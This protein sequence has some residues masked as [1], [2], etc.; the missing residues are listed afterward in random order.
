MNLGTTESASPRPV[1]AA[2]RRPTSICYCAH[3]A[4]L[5]TTTRVVILQ[6]P[7]ERDVAIGTARMA[8]LCLPNSELHVGVRWSDSPALARVLSDPARPAVLL[9]P[10]EG[11]IDVGCCPPSGP[12]TLVVVDGTWWQARKVIR[13]NPALA[14]LPRY[15]FVPPSPSEYR[16]RRE[17]ASA[18]VSTI[19]A[20]AHVLGVLEGDATRFSAL[21]A[22][23]RAMIDAQIAC[24]RRYQGGR[25]RHP[26]GPRPPKRRAPRLLH[27][28]AADVLC[29]SGEA[30]A[31]PHRSSERRGGRP[32]EIVQWTAFRPSTGEHFEVVAAPRGEL[33]PRTAHHLEVPLAGLQG[34]CS[35]EALLARWRAFVRETDVLCAWG[36]YAT[37]LFAAEGAYLPATRVDLRLATRILANRR[38]GTIDDV[39]LSLGLPEAPSLGEGRAGRRLGQLVALTRHLDA[40]AAREEALAGGKP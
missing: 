14:A 19:E 26:K 2:C 9:Y 23:F 7:R 35:R 24:E 3:V 11:A 25:I 10:G 21:L 38:V 1:C 31:W 13:E 40:V 16:I 33:A 4:P 28:R 30:N 17:P 29:V 39:V 6:H 12:V 27:T 18:C 15:A 37:S 32:E 36:S 8:A 34:G 5:D 22:P 20:L